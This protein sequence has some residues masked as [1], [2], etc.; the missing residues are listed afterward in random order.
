MG[1]GVAQVIDHL[2]NNCKGLHSTPNTRKKSS[3]WWSVPI[4]PATQ[5]VWAGGSQ[6]KA[7]PKS[8]ENPSEK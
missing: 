6:F 8:N 3:A 4:I 5:E 1:D 7:N 2:P